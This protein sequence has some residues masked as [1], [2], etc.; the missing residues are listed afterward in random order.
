MVTGRRSEP[1]NIEAIP[2]PV[3]CAD[4]H[5]DEDEDLQCVH[6]SFMYTQRRLGIMSTGSPGAGT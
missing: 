2:I 5:V 6:T 1:S 4:V 3:P